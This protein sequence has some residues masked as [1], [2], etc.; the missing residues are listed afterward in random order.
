MANKKIH[1]RTAAPSPPSPHHYTHGRRAHTSAHM[2][3][4]TQGRQGTLPRHTRDSPV[5]NTRDARATPATLPWLPRFGGS[6]RAKPPA[7]PPMQL[8]PLG[9]ERLVR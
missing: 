7:T 1:T 6:R 2:H 3:T 4:H 5:E 8:P 9:L